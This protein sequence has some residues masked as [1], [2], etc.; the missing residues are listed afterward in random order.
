MPNG[1]S[2][3]QLAE[4]IAKESGSLKV[5]FTSGYSAEML[6]STP[7]SNGSLNFLAKPYDPL[8]LLKIVRDALDN[9]SAEQ[10][11]TT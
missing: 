7:L 8:K 10:V 4:R 1:I 2:G 11:L 3:I 6:E 5:V 9:K